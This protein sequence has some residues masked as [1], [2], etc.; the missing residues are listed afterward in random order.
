V[1]IFKK[2]SEFLVKKG[3]IFSLA[4]VLLAVS[5]CKKKQKAVTRSKSTEVR[6]NIDIPVAEDGIKS[7]FDEDIKEFALADDVNATSNPD[8]ISTSIDAAQ[9]PNA[10]EFS[11]DDAQNSKFKVV[12]FDYDK[13]NVRADQEE[14]LNANI[15]FAKQTIDEAVAMGAQV[16]T[17]V[18]DGHACHSAGSRVYN[19]ALSEKRAKVLADRFVEAG[20]ARENIKIVGRGSEVPALVNGQVCQGS[21]E[22]QAPNRRD[23]LRIIYS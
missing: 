10:H 3:Y 6:A 11:W 9:S 5:G 12:Y 4:I 19:L 21:R 7:F 20:I 1:Y 13:Y 14:N 17:V 18:I 22:Q 8:V 16:P 23:E 15:A 2:R